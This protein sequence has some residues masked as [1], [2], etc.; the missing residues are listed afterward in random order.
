MQL[1]AYLKELTN[2][3][4]EERNEIVSQQLELQIRKIAEE[5]IYHNHSISVEEMLEN[6]R[7]EKRFKRKVF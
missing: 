7:R 3:L 5:L 1:E 2:R 4:K 6:I